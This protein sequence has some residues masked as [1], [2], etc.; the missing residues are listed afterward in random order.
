MQITHISKKEWIERLQ[1]TSLLEQKINL[2]LNPTESDHAKL[3][4]TIRSSIAILLE[5]EKDVEKENNLVALTDDVL[6]QSQVILKR[7]WERVKSG[8]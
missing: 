8:D 3:V 7:E 2:L 1:R 6:K 5:E 4:T